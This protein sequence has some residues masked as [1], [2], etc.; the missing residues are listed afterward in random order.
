MVVQILSG[1][2]HKQLFFS[3]REKPSQ[4]GIWT[5]DLLEKL[6]QAPSLPSLLSHYIEN[7]L[8]IHGVHG[9][10]Q[11]QIFHSWLEGRKFM[12]NILLPQSKIKTNIHKEIQGCIPFFQNQIQY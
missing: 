8:S 2:Y 5:Q 6:Y 12:L 3:S 9:S 1:I 4:T 11:R 10:T 7:D